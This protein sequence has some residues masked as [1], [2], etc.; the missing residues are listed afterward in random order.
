MP[1]SALALGDRLAPALERLDER[2]RLAQLLV[3][4]RLPE[5]GEVGLRAAAEGLARRVGGGHDEGRFALQ[6][7]DEAAGVARGN[8]EHAPLDAGVVEHAARA[9]PDRSP[10]A[11]A[12]G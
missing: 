10:A 5:V 7:L 8:G 12:A 4:H 9:W 1:P 2:V 6:G 11:P 3:E